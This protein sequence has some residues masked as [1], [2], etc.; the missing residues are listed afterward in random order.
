[1]SKTDFTQQEFDTRHAAVRRAMSEKGIDLLVVIAPTNIQYL[2]GSR[3]K[4]Y[5]EFQCLL[6][7]LDPSRPKVVL[8][9]LAEVGR[10][11][12]RADARTFSGAQAGKGLIL[13]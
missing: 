2:I 6:F 7:P 9:R 10:H 4:S 8:T 5:Q 11:P 12:F 3:T 1:M 13:V